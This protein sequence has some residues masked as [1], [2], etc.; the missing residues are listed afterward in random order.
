MAI[1]FTSY[2]NHKTKNSF[3][4]YVEHHLHIINIFIV[5]I[6]L[7]D[8]VVITGYRFGILQSIHTLIC[9]DKI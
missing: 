1:F 3:N 6:S 2:I 5:K 4:S 8:I 7:F 9:V